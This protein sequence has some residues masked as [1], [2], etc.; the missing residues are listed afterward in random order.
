MEL[1]RLDKWLW[2][3]RFYKT[4]SLA[5]QAVGGGK[6]Q[7]NGDRV[8]PAKELRMGDELSIRIGALLWI[9][10]VRALSEQRRGAPEAQKL[11]EEKEESKARRLE[12]LALRKAQVDPFRDQRGRP[13]KKDRRLIRRFTESS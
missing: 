10:V 7:V 5:S 4:R 8:K 1:V 9:V 2:A 3:A 6:V 12:A 11:Y 13:T